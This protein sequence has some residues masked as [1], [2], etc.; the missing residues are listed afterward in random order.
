MELYITNKCILCGA[1]NQINN[2]IFNITNNGA[3]PNN[4]KINFNNVNDCYDAIYFCP[5][6]AI[7][8]K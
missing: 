1:C 7:H 6:N 8:E 4:E 2:S 3:I 5:A